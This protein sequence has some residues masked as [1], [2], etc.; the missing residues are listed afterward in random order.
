MPRTRANPFIGAVL[1]SLMFFG[2]GSYWIATGKAHFT[3]GGDDSKSAAEDRHDVQVRAKGREAYALGLGAYGLGVLVLA[4]GMRSDRRIPVFFL[5][6]ALLF[7]GFVWRVG[8][9]LGLLP[10]S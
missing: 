7:G 10:S 3:L 5:G 6:L 1:A 8:L 9:A 2:L 4:Q